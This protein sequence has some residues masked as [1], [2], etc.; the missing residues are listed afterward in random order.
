M[1]EL[2]DLRAGLDHAHIERGRTWYRALSPDGS[3]WCET[4][5]PREVAES[6]E[7][8]DGFTLQQLKCYIVRTP[9][10]SWEAEEAG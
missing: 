6:I 8:K 7:G 10:E 4:S 1:A 2:D 5:N 9:W 3:L